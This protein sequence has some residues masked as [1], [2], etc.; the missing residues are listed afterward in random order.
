MVL[1]GSHLKVRIYR[2]W[3]NFIYSFTCIFA[4]LFFFFI[5]RI[6]SLD[7]LSCFIQGHAAQSG[8]STEWLSHLVQPWWQC[9]R[10]FWN[11][12]KL[13]HFHYHHVLFLFA[14]QASL[15]DSQ[16]GMVQLLQ[17]DISNIDLLNNVTRGLANFS[18]YPQ[19]VSRLVGC[20]FWICNKLKLF[21]GISS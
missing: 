21:K 20:L 11:W 12:F 13:K 4:C 2:D 7:C 9:D 14:F 6:M 3:I 18:R 5:L 19:N 1:I 15:S 10:I 8:C 17:T 16:D